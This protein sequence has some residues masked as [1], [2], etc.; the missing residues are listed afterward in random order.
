MSLLSA[1]LYALSIAVAFIAG[2][3]YGKKIGGDR[4]V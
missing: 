1:F 4:G 3:E 2:Y